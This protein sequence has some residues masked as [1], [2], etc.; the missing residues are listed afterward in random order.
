MDAAR[1]HWL[2]ETGVNC[3]MTRL[4]GR[5]MAGERVYEYV[6]DVRFERTSLV[7][8]LGLGGVVAPLAYKGSLDG[9][10]FAAY[11]KKRLAPAM[12]RGDTL[13]LDNLSAHKVKGA[14]GPLAKKGVK[15]VFLPVYSQDFNPIEHAWSKVKACLRKLKARTADELLPAM[16]VALDSVTPED[17]RGWIR[18]CGYGLQ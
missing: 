2:D 3:G 14:L 11:V 13:I 6:P 12:R 17:C 16:A 15:V 5:A 8:A 1:T 18:H 4:Y 7:G 9:E 10:F